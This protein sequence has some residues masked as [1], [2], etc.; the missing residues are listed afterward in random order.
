MR[1][2]RQSLA[3]LLF[4]VWLGGLPAGATIKKTADE[5]PRPSRRLAQDPADGSAVY[6]EGEVLVKFKKMLTRSEAGMLARDLAANE[7]REFAL[8][9]QWRQ[10]AYALITSATATT[11]ELLADLRSRP[12]VEAVS[13][14][15]RRSR[16]RLPN[17]PKFPRL[18]GMTKIAAPAA[19]EKSIGSPEVV[20]AVMD[21]GV[22]YRHEDLAANMWRNPGEIPANGVDDD[23]NGF[24]DDVYGYDFSAGKDGGTDGDPMDI[25][26]HG[27]HIAGIMAAVGD[28]GRGVCGVN[29]NAKVM[30][31]KSFRPDG[32]LYDSDAIA[33][34]E[35]AVLM[36][37]NYGVNLVAINASFGGTGDNPLQK[38]AIAEAG[39]QGIILV[40]AAGN[41]GVDGDQTP[42]YPAGYDL[43]NIISVAASDGDDRLA[44]FSNYG[45]NSVDIAA[46]G[47]NILSTFPSGKGLTGTLLSGAS[48]YDAI[49]M[50]F[51]G[52]TAVTGLAAQLVD[53]GRGLDSASFPPAVWGNI[54]LI[55]RGEK[56]FA[57]KTHL[58]QNAGAVAAV[59]FNNEADIFSGTLGEAGNWI[60]VVSLAREDGL[61]EKALGIHPVTLVIGPADYDYMEGTSMAA[62]Y[63]CGAL[64]LLAA[65][66]PADAMLKRIARVYSGADRLPSL[67]KKI[68]IGARLN[69]ARS[70]EQSLLLTL[71]VFRQQV[72]VW[73][74]K[75]DFAEVYFSVENDPGSGVSGAT[76]G[77]YRSSGGGFEMIKEIAASELHDN[78][79]TYYDKYL[80]R[81]MAYTYLIQARNAQGEV[82][83]SST[84]E[85]I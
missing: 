78:S 32:F 4:I 55:E 46:P 6:R 50:E 28:N 1:W 35:Y 80:D 76:Y 53:C 44:D 14:N 82:I 56:T 59:I 21:T 15:Y 79:Y 48:A 40:C 83:A 27:T 43:P 51:S 10:C 45:A 24:V 72:N 65:T 54:A 16:Q 85:S 20:L 7:V 58:A 49:P 84:P 71:A 26:T 11:G 63:V 47:T 41:D 19:W 2:K 73:V 8:L 13:P 37:R 52:S 75:K 68:R 64:G 67:D 22:D 69:L 3:A 36:K 30:A 9:S 42:F 70:L 33:A 18:W 62:P 34:I 12:E 39:S 5:T 60:P 31:L 38:D 29:W 61:Q 25:E 66:Y 57:E 74:L 17:D 77:I 23:G 81:G